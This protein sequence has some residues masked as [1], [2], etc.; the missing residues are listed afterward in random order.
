MMHLRNLEMGVLPSSLSQ[1]YDKL[2]EILQ[3]PI[4]ILET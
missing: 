1:Q 4:K 2:W 3:I